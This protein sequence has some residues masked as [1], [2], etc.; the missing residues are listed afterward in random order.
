MELFMDQI[1]VQFFEVRF[2]EVVLGGLGKIRAVARRNEVNRLLRPVIDL[3]RKLNRVWCAADERSR[4]PEP[5]R[6]FGGQPNG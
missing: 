3:L 4:Q 1:R 2:E 5:E 6:S